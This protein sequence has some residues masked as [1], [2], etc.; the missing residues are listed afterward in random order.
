[1]V[2]IVAVA[3]SAVGNRL[4]VRQDRL[5]RATLATPAVTADL[6]RH[7]L[8]DQMTELTAVLSAAAGP[9]RGPSGGR[10]GR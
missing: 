10:Q 7:A 4:S 8:Q 6:V 2:P 5:L 3:M 9:R 1:V